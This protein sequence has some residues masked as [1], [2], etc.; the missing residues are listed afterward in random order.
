MMPSDWPNQQREVTKRLLVSDTGKTFDVLGWYSPTIVKAK[1]LLQRVWEAKI[2]WDEVLPQSLQ[3]EGFQWRSELPLIT[4]RSID[5]CYYLKSGHIRSFQLHGFC[6]ASELAYAGTVYLRMVDT[7]GH[8]HVSLVTS[9]TKV[10][11]IK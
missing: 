3:E 5:R 6:D 2:D 1:I 11:P 10:A 9:K 7:H 8:V 4:E